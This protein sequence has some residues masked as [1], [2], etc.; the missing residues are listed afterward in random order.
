MARSEDIL[1]LDV[2]VDPGSSCPRPPATRTGRPFRAGTS[3]WKAL[4]V[5]VHGPSDESLMRESGAFERLA[6]SSN[7]PESPK[8]Q[9]WPVRSGNFSS[10]PMGSADA[11]PAHPRRHLATHAPSRR[12]DRKRTSG[13]FGS[14]GDVA[15]HDSLGRVCTCSR[16]LPAG[17]RRNFWKVHAAAP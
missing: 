2:S 17:G 15:V 5:S 14:D 6:V 7:F 1:A 3:H 9:P 4:L 16:D 10:R 12:G 8:P 11:L 13:Q